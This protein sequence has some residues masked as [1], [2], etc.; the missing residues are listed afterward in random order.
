MRPLTLRGY[1]K[2]YLIELS[3]SNTASVSKLLKELPENPRLQE[4]LVVYAILNNTSSNICRKNLQFYQEYVYIKENFSHLA[5]LSGNY[6]KL[7]NSYHYASSRKQNDD[8]TKQKMRNRILIIQKEKHI[9]NYRIYMDLG[10]NPSNV[11]YFLKHGNCDKLHID[12]VRKI[13][14]YLETNF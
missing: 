9:T 2:Q 10:L 6:Q 1:L 12:T 4:P 8:D 14:K 3:Y 13:W 11:N 5:Q 7:M